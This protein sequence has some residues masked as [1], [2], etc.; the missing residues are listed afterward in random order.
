MVAPHQAPKLSLYDGAEHFLPNY[1]RHLTPLDSARE[2][3]EVQ[4]KADLNQWPCKV[5]RLNSVTSLQ[6][7]IGEKH[8]TRRPS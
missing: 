8:Q 2:A 1:S 7:D 6:K 5:I 3:A 4:A